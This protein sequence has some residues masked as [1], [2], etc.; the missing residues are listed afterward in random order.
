M[1]FINV[2]ILYNNLN[3]FYCILVLGTHL[4]FPIFYAFYSKIHKSGQLNSQLWLAER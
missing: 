4:L 3:I 1:V 2:T